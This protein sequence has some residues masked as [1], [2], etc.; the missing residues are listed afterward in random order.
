LYVVP[1]FPV[2]NGGA[3]RISPPGDNFTPIQ[4]TF[5]PLGDKLAPGGKV[6]P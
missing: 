6:C 3:N 1:N 5:S 2:K 4:G